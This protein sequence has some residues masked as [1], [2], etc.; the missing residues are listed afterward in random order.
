VVDWLCTLSQVRR[1]I[2][3]LTGDTVDDPYLIE[4]IPR[5]STRINNIT[6]Q[7]YIPW[8]ELYY[9]DAF[10]P[11]I[12]DVYRK[13]DLGRPI[14][15]PV[16]VVDALKNTLVLNTDYVVVPQDS[17]GV[18]LQRI[19]VIFGWSYGIGYGIGF[20]LAPIQFQRAIQI[21][22]IW[23]Y[24]TNYPFEGWVDSLQ[25]L[26]DTG[27]ING[28]DVVST[29]KVTDPGAINSN[30]QTPAIDVGNVLQLTNTSVTPNTYEWMQVIAVNETNKTLTALRGINGST[31]QAWPLGT[32]VFTW[33][34]QP[35]INKACVR[36]V[37]YAY[38]RRG[39]FEAV[40]N[41]LSPAGA[42]TYVYPDDAPADVIHI[43][44]Q[45]RDW[46]WGIV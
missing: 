44:E 3:V 15:T 1:E 36:W 2:K 9:Y 18:Q 24:R 46:R 37:A 29:F 34:V 35:E 31:K 8:Y 21:T 26:T 5:I 28:T 43:L 40:K 41:D 39:A 30:A 45:T 42:K 7:R 19:N 4:N 17:P 13:L 27:G 6:R 10:G 33:D 22:G 14:L 23:G 38:S 11:G 25:A 32:E 12:D 16:T 20:W